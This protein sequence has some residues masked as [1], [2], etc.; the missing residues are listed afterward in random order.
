MCVVRTFKSISI[1]S[2]S[3]GSCFIGEDMN[4]VCLAGLYA[5]A[6]SIASTSSSKSS[7]AVVGC[8]SSFTD[9]PR[10]SNEAGSARVSSS[11]PSALRSSISMSSASSIVEEFA[12]EAA[13]GVGGRPPAEVFVLPTA[14]SV[15]SPP[16]AFEC[17]RPRGDVF[18]ASSRPTTAGLDVDF[19]FAFFG[20]EL[21]F[22]EPEPG[23]PTDD[24]EEEVRLAFDFDDRLELDEPA[25]LLGFQNSNAMGPLLDCKSVLLEGEN[26]VE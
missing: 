20:F 13:P 6:R 1:A 4:G 25:A 11:P 12:L 24:D 8:E 5:V 21:I 15:M 17:R 10:A 16:R 19:D 26:W 3:S 14:V 22:V 23:L 2:P 7:S 9:G 18:E